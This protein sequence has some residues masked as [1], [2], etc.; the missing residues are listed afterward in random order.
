MKRD[1]QDELLREFLSG[2]EVSDFRRVSLERGLAEMQ[3]QRWERRVAKIG[4]AA[5]ALLAAA[6]IVFQHGNRQT[7]HEMA[8]VKPAS[9]I[10]SSE[11]KNPEVKI[12][13]DEELF[14]L[15]PGRAMALVGKQGEQQLV[16]LDGGPARARVR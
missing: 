2:E 13:S 7:A 9:A 5:M 15:F 6:A 10:E 14:A 11:T 12:I 4:V 1:E 3:R 8:S 16:F